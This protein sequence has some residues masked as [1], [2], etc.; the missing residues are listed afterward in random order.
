M[1]IEVWCT[2][3]FEGFHRWDAAPEHVDYLRQPHRHMFH[4]KCWWKVSHTDRDIEFITEKRRV[5][6]EI[7][8]QQTR[9]VSRWSCERWAQWLCDTFNCCRAEVSEDGENG[10]VFYMDTITHDRL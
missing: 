6:I 5:D 2:G 3:S 9:D 4:W 1:T 8:Y 10:A 7:R